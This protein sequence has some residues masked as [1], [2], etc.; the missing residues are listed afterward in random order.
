MKWADTELLNRSWLVKGPIPGTDEK[1]EL[2]L[3]RAKR[4]VQLAYKAASLDL[5]D[6]LSRG[7][8]T[9]GDIR[10]VQVDLALA[11][12]K[13]PMGARSLNETTGPFSG[14]MTFGGDFL[15]TLS[16]TEEMYDMLGVSSYVITRRTGM[17]ETW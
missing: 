12:L 1:L 14:G 17:R 15:G 16:L 11:V 4:K 3:E 13:N 5:E 7:L 8:T 10:S 6:A 2:L 9:E